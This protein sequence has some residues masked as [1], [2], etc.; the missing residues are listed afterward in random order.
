VSYN[1]PYIPEIRPK[2]EYANYAGR[3]SVEIGGCHDLILIA[4]AHDVYREIDF[5][6]LN[7]PVVDTRN[8]TAGMN[9]MVYRA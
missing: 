9:G 3:K 7:V 1:D 6:T 4:T 2:R 5:R 8:L